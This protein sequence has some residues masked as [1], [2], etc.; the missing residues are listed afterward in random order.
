MAS[1]Q[2]NTN[3]EMI[4]DTDAERNQFIV[5]TKHTCDKCLDPILGKRYTTGGECNFDLCSSCFNGEDGLKEAVL[6]KYLFN[7][8]LARDKKRT[9]DFV[10]KLKIDNEGDGKYLYAYT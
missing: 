7:F 3:S 8:T 6:G 9:H 4:S 2:D 5:H 10:L 1:K